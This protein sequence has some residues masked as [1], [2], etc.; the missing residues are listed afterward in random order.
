MLVRLFIVV[1]ALLNMAG[2]FLGAIGQINAYGYGAVFAVTVG[3][4]VA[5]I[6]SHKMPFVI[7]FQAAKWKVI[8]RKTVWRYSKA[9]PFS[10]FVFLLISVASGVLFEP[11][12]SDG[13]TYRLPRILHWIH[14][15]RWYW[16]PGSGYRMNTRGVGLEW[17]QLP[18][19]LFSKSNC[20]LFWPSFFSYLCLPGLV[21]SAFRRLGVSRQ[22]AWW[23]MWILPSGYGL[24]L[25]ASNI[26]NDLIAVVFALA[27]LDFALRAVDQR[28][29]SDAAFSLISASLMTATKQPMLVLLL[30]WIVAL[31]PAWRLFWENKWKTVA[32]ALAALPA[33]IVPITIENLLHTGDWSGVVLEP[34]L[35]KAHNP[36]LCLFGNVDLFILQNIVPPLFI[37]Q[38][39]WIETYGQFLTTPLG[40]LLAANFETD[41][42]WLPI[43]LT[44]HQASLGL[45]VA[46]LVGAACGYHLIA[47]KSGTTRRLSVNQRCIMWATVIAWMVFLL[48]TGVWQSGRLLIPHSFYLIPFLLTGAEQWRL[49]HLRWWRV[50]VLIVMVHMMFCL[51]FIAPRSPLA[52]FGIGRQF[53]ISAV[54]QTKESTA[55][56]Q[57]NIP[58]TE[59]SIGVLRRE[60]D[61][62][63]WLW[64]PYESRN[65]VS[66]LL[67]TDDATYD[68]FGIHYIVLSQL[69][70][71]QKHVSLDEWLH[72]HSYQLVGT[73]DMSYHPWYLIKR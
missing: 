7:D 12:H 62:E 27:A 43:R 67:E 63:V 26:G 30:P 66:L 56:V 35:I 20:S 58:A 21:F 36:L 5:L 40:R 72:R 59:R 57:Q 16:I 51:V 41:F 42:L 61:S 17:M 14:E 28:R 38:Q 65:V 68:S 73:I 46:V 23:W 52:A 60:I 33:S 71:D 4:S 18:F 64:A 2:W 3:I 54:T 13:L 34:D 22:V 69:L 15:Q 10:F 25:G 50:L 70:L 8:A 29:F 47:K 32:I 44:S 48:S 24:V 55:W 49:V 39:W 9:L 37:W 19:L 53:Y 31:A 45:G 6:R 1:S 11:D